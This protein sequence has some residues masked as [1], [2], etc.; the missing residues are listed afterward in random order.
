MPAQFDLIAGL[1]PSSLSQLTQVQ[2][3]Q[4]INQIA[5]LSHIGLV[6]YAVGTSLAATIPQGTLGSPSVTDNPRYARYVWLNGMSD[7]PTPYY[8]D[9]NTGNWTS[10]TVAALSVTNA[11]IAANAAIAVSK[12]AVGTAYFVI[13]TNAAGTAVEYI[14]PANLYDSIKL[15]IAGIAPNGA[16]AFLKTVGGALSWQTDAA[17][18]A[19]FQAA[20]SA[21][22]VAQ[23]AA[24]T[25]GYVISTVGGVPVWA[26]AG[27][28]FGAG[29]NI[30]LTA[31]ADGGAAAGDILYWS[32][33]AWVVAT[34]SLQ[35]GTSAAISTSGLVS[36][37]DAGG[38]AIDGE[39]D[40]STHRVPHGFGSTPPKLI[41]MVVYCKGVDAASGY[42]VGDEIDPLNWLFD[43]GAGSESQL[44][45]IY[46]GTDGYVYVALR[47]VTLANIFVQAKGAGAAAK[48]NVTA[49]SNFQVKVYAWK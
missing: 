22:P 7:V 11:Q 41:R 47:T 26:A 16:N 38:A 28:V 25:N 36:A 33:S 35:I 9:S 49:L 18:Q 31:L 24:G 23:L 6:V 42:A 14:S 45:N 44:F 21:L 30:P 1:D 43:N 19:A 15:P 32:G 34:Q 5:P 29:S 27:T 46:S 4:I 17:A 37:Q 39:I 10:T 20:I 48:V 13:R 8:Y 12:L 3:L 40:N 2:L